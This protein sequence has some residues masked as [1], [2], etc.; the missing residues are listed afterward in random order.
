MISIPMKNDVPNN[1]SVN[2]NFRLADLYFN[3]KNYI[4]RHLYISFNKYLEEDIPRFLTTPDNVH[5]VHETITEN[6]VYKHRFIYN[7][8]VIES[9]SQ[10]NGVEPLFPID[11]RQQSLSYSVKI[12][13]DV[14]QE[15]EIIDI[16]TYS[17]DKTGVFKKFIGEEVKQVPIATQALM[18]RSKYCNLNKY[19][20]VDK[21]ECEYDPG[22][23]FIVNG[24]EKIIICQDKMVENKPLVY[25][26]KDGG[27]LYYIAQIN[28]KSPDIMGTNQ[29]MTIKLKK[30][31]IITIKIS[32]FNDINVFMLMRAL[33][34]ESDK[35]IID[36]TIYDVNDIYAINVIRSSLDN[37][38]NERDIKVTTKEEA[39]DYL[40]TKL[41]ITSKKY[42]ETNKQVRQEQRRMHL[43][44]LLTHSFLPHI[45]GTLLEKGYFLGYMINKIIN[46][47]LGRA[48]PD[49]RDS[50]LNKT[51]EQ[52]G[53]LLFDLFK[54][55]YKKMMNECNKFFMSRNENEENPVNIIHQ[56]K[57]NI[58]EQGIKTALLTGTWIRKKGVAQMLQRLTYLQT[59]SFMRR[60][61][62]PGGDN[63]TMKLTSPRQLHPSA[64][65]FLCCVTGDTEILMGDNTV[66]LIKNLKNDDSVMSIHIPSLKAEPTKIHSFFCID[67]PEK[68]IEVTLLHSDKK[69]KCT[70][71]HPLLINKN[72][73]LKYINAGELN[74]GDIVVTICNNNINNK[75]E[76]KIISIKEIT[77][78]PVYDFTTRN[79]AHS[80]IAN[81]IITHNCVQTPEHVKVGLTKHLNILASLTIMERSVYNLIYDF[82]VRYPTL[83]KIG[84]AP[85]DTFRYMYKVFLNGEW[86]GLVEN[87]VEF[88]KDLHE[89][90]LTGF[91]GSRNMSVVW[92]YE[93]L[94]M[95]IR[96]D[97]GRMYRPVLN[98]ENNSCN[99]NK[100][101]LDEISLNKADQGKITDW[102][103]FMIKYPNVVEYIDVEEQPY[104][105]LAENIKIVEDMR[106][107]MEASKH[108][109]IDIKDNYVMNRYDEM[110]FLKYSHM[111]IHPSLLLGEISINVPFIDRNVGPR[112]IFEYSQGKQAMG[113]YSTNYRYRLDIS[114]ILYNPQRQLI[115]TRGSRYV[116]T[117][118]LP[119]G[120]NAIVAIACYTG[121]NQEDSLIFNK[122]SIQRGLFRSMSLRKYVLS[123]ER[124]Q[125]TL[126]D[127]IFM[128]PDPTKVI[129]MKH[130]SYDKLNDQG[131]VN[132]E[133]VILNNEI[134]MG[135]VTPIQGGNSDTT[136]QF[137]DSSESY[138]SHA[139][140]VI[141]RNY[142]GLQNQD[143]YESRKVLVRSERIPYI[144]DKF[145]IKNTADVLTYNGW[146][147]IA[148]VTTED[149]VATLVDGEKIK[150]ENPTEIYKVMYNGLMYELRSQQV[151]L[152]VTIDHK[153][154]VKLEGSNSF[155][156]IAASDV[157]GKSYKLKKNGIYDTPDVKEEWLDEMI[158]KLV[159]DTD[160]PTWVW[161]LNTKQANKV[162]EKLITIDTSYTF[163]DE[164]MK[165]AIHAGHG[166]CID[167]RGYLTLT[168]SEPEIRKDNSTESTYEYNDYVYC[169]EV[170]SHVFMIR[171]NNKN[172]WVG[173][174]SMMGQ[175]G[176]IGILLDQMDMPF[177]KQGM[178]PDIILNPN[179]IPS[180]MTIGQ[181]MECLTGKVA[182]IQG[183]DADG[184]P[185]ED[186][187]IEAIKQKLE[188]LGYNR[189]GE[190]ELYNGM[191]GEKL[192][193]NIF[194]GPTYYQRL[195]HLVLDKF[196]PRAIKYRKI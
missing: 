14:R 136:K 45:K 3:K 155:E 48:P 34:I 116:N 76:L 127:D 85:V 126:Q 94:E 71:D 31:A 137:R 191:T 140:G 61:D 11:A 106:K 174:C 161:E 38:K 80:F 189:N 154:Y 26:K 60:I 47:E 57:P 92:D 22:G 178:H 115:H 27:V 190:E 183:M 181:L 73:E 159:P 98:L 129:G 100:N 54:Q 169:L 171:Q 172:V 37:C 184:T 188:D 13:A 176:T 75:V 8:I 20:G 124:N 125:S 29:I 122:T 59:I 93:K 131:Y 133:T 143:G 39:I 36:Y 168:K 15:L 10:N 91:F 121:Y 41:R 56:I 167:N 28:S 164:L 96:C 53:D 149:L 23:Y 142:I 166:T 104:L 153:L 2:D 108:I 113:I 102:N 86:L 186:Y 141:D 114:Y 120:E 110:F 130:G 78:E 179:A 9:P 49:D 150:Y 84:N 21:Y 40:L 44:D 12:L 123:V 18:L 32:I 58:I 33:G 17:K 173:N 135:K 118:M 138:K 180:R 81:G 170:P 185:F 72:Q 128:K 19:K 148:N 147:P 65:G 79:N 194:I 82:L 195:K 35:S 109:K 69:L 90:K 50:Y 107:R 132:E 16:A 196:C 134:I 88:Y 83:I 74:V 43:L 175:K 77:P 46:V 4:Y 25:S 151:D 139:P 52:P 117:R 42:S 165:L 146:K 163:K 87:S 158:N 68:M 112:N 30:D 66:E 24:S 187:D 182:S 63:A 95:R 156:R 6:K 55:Q 193:V 144:G 111:E 157:I 119:S 105:L 1:L 192:R 160:L 152:D 99:L 67:K 51:V 89:K 145:C 177:T 101:I 5:T 162:V 62:S 97:S 103:D 70:L 64:V 7:N